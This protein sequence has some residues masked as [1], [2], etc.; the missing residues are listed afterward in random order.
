MGCKKTK[1]AGT[2]SAE[3][4]YPNRKKKEKT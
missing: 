3:G 1:K 2:S 4:L